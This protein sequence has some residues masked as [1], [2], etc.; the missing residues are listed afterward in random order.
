M[1]AAPGVDEAEV[2][3][4]AGAVEDASE[5]PIAAAIAT[6]AKEEFGLLPAVDEFASEAGVG[7]RG[8]VG[9][10]A[11]V[12]GRAA[13]S[14]RLCR[15]MG[16]QKRHALPAE[17]AAARSEAEARGQ[18]AIAVGWD[19][20]VRGLVVVADTVKPIEPRGDRRS[21]ASSACGRC[22]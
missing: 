2:L 8:V 13:A 5:H 12:V 14:C 3:R 11:V 22:C 17:L 20:E 16:P 19:G 10:R 4:L 1:H 7:V 9:G 21:C 15:T 18:T 6:R